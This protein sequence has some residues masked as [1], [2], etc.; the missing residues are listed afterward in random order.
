MMCQQKKMRSIQTVKNVTISAK[1]NGQNFDF[2]INDVVGKSSQEDIFNKTSNV[3]MKTIVLDVNSPENKTKISFNDIA[4]DT[5]SELVNGFINSSGKYT[6]V[7]TTVTALQSSTIAIDNL[8]IAVS[9]EHVSKEAMLALQTMGLSAD[10][11]ADQAKMLEAMDKMLKSGLTFDIKA[12]DI[13]KLNLN[14]AQGMPPIE[15]KNFKFNLHAQLKENSLDLSS[16][17]PMMYLPFVT[18]EGK[19]EIDNADLDKLVMINPMVGMLTGLK[20]VEGTQAVFAYA[21][22]EGKLTI[23]GKP[24]PF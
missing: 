10:P 18:L 11:T 7:R 4:L 8:V 14:M 20:K 16:G 21:F 15:V 1:G 6:I 17:N 13:A 22:K 9:G 24:L 19:I 5:T 23:N 3:L 2:S 12:F